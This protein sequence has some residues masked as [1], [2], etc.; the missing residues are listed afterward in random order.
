MGTCPIFHLFLFHLTEETC[1][2]CR[3][4]QQIQLYRLDRRHPSVLCSARYIK[5]PGASSNH[6][7]K[8]GYISSRCWEKND[9]FELGFNKRVFT[10]YST[11]PWHH[12][13]WTKIIFRTGLPH[14]GYVG[15]HTP[16][17]GAVLQRIEIEAA[18]NPSQCSLY[19]I[20]GTSSNHVGK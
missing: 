12:R 5:S 19:H 10:K 14:H 9:V 16:T 20:L 2:S 17:L 13:Q 6:V 4:A 18:P 15:N 7:G 1:S 3:I 8:Q 11:G